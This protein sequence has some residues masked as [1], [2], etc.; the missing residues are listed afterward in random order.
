MPGMIKVEG[1]CAVALANAQDAD[2]V[3][4]ACLVTTCMR[5]RWAAGIFHVVDP[6]SPRLL[7]PTHQFRGD[8]ENSA[9]ALR[10]TAVHARGEDIGGLAG[11]ALDTGAAA[12]V[13][14][15]SNEATFKDPA[16]AQLMGL[17]SALAV[18][19]YIR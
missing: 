1:T 12:W 7:R 5:Q 10:A 2:A 18:P 19:I 6:S 8:Q 11:R 4:E 15:V 9:T 3:I 14:D 17:T 13:E 16:H